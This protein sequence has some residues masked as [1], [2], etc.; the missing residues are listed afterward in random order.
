[1]ANYVWG[2]QNMLMD[3][4]DENFLNLVPS[5]GDKCMRHW[6]KGEPVIICYKLVFFLLLTVVVLANKEMNGA[7]MGM[8]S[9]LM[10]DPQKELH[11]D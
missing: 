3:T 2:K 11:W 8:V 7:P 5:Y 6:K 10:N 4:T 1:M 9:I